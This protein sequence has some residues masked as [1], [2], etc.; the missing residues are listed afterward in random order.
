MHWLSNGSKHSNEGQPSNWLTNV[1]NFF[2]VDPTIASKPE[3]EEDKMLEEEW[4][5]EVKEMEG[6]TG[7]LRQEATQ[8][9]NKQLEERERRK[10]YFRGMINLDQ[11]I[12]NPKFG[13]DY[14][15]FTPLTQGKSYNDLI[16]CILLSKSSWVQSSL[17]S[18]T[19][20]YR[21][22]RIFL[23]LIKKDS[24][25]HENFFGLAKIYFYKNELNESI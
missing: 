10:A 25:M 17:I 6:D 11:E 14:S 20:L 8:E 15:E 16:I 2:K 23:D 9:S 13:V 12:N 7:G 1:L 19:E 21:T 24:K 22:E 3:N 18:D 4:K 5:K